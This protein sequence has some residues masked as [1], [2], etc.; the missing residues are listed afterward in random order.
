MGRPLLCPR[1]SHSAS[2][3][4]KLEWRLHKPEA[5]MSLTIFLSG[6]LALLLAPGPTN[7]LI[8][9]S[10]VSEGF[11]RTLRLLP[12]EL[13]AYLLIVVPL[14][15]MGDGL[16]QVWPAYSTALTIAAAIWI[17]ALALRIWRRGSATAT[18]AISGW[19]VFCTTLL[20]PK[21]LVFGLV[22]LPSAT[23]PDFPARIAVFALSVVAAA[24]IWSAGGAL[25]AG[26]SRLAS[27]HLL[28][29]L[30]AGWLGLVSLTL[31]SRVLVG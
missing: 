27:A 3:G 24:L 10:A 30:A 19:T 14:S 5:P 21:A 16:M 20:N 12:A 28:H 17:M 23:S 26:C 18:V 11:R 8:A 6:I 2:T 13:M 4:P 15:V 9:L 7:T 25:L 22:L 1:G 29:R 31:V